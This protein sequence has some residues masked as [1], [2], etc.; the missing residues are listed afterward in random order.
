[1]NHRGSACGA[2]TARASIRA[3]APACAVILAASQ[4]P[5]ADPPIP[6]GNRLVP[7][8]V[9]DLDGD[10][11]APVIM[12]R[13]ASLAHIEDVN[14]R[15]LF[16]ATSGELAPTQGVVVVANHPLGTSQTLAVPGGGTPTAL[17]FYDVDHDGDED[18]TVAVFEKVYESINTGGVYG[19]LVE[20]I[21]NAGVNI[22][23]TKNT[24]V[25]DIDAGNNAD[26][27]VAVNNVIPPSTVISELRVF[28]GAG[29]GMYNPP[30]VYPLPGA[31]LGSID[32]GRLNNDATPDIAV[33]NG[34]GVIILRNDGGG[35]LSLVDKNTGAALPPGSP[36][37][38]ATVPF[39]VTPTEIV[40]AD[41]NN[42]SHADL[43]ACDFTN[44]RIRAGNGDG[45]FSSTLI[46]LAGDVGTQ[47]LAVGDVNG[48]KLPEIFAVNPNRDELN[49]WTATAPLVYAP[50]TIHA[51]GHDPRALIIVDLTGDGQRDL[52][53][54]HS[55]DGTNMA[56]VNKGD[57]T[58]SFGQRLGE[59]STIQDVAVSDFN[60]D[61]FPD[62]VGG[63][64]SGN[65]FIH[66]NAADG[67]G[68]LLPTE[69]P[70]GDRVVVN[71]VGIVALPGP[72]ALAGDGRARFAIAFGSSFGWLEYVPTA[73]LGRRAVARG[74]LDTGFTIRGIAPCDLNNDG[75]TDLGVVFA[76]TNPCARIYTQDASGG[77][78]IP[79]INIA[80]T[81]AGDFDRITISP[82]SSGLPANWVF[83]FDQQTGRTE[84]QEYNAGFFTFK[85]EF[86]SGAPGVGAAALG[87]IDG[88]GRDDLLVANANSADGT[89]RITVQTQI[90]SATPPPPSF[91]PLPRFPT[92]VAV[93]DIDGDGKA[94]AVVSTAG[95]TTQTQ[96]ALVI[97]NTGTS[98]DPNSIT[99]HSIGG[100]PRRIVLADLNNNPSRGT[101]ADAGPEI[102]S[103]DSDPPLGTIN[104]SITVLPNLANFAQPPA[105]PGDADGDNAVGL[106]D[107]ALMIQNWSDPGEPPVPPFTLGDL[108]GDGFVK[109]EDLA[110]VIIN[111]NTT[112]P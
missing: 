102:I 7:N 35:A 30:T 99:F 93:G 96:H 61:G 98:L 81:S 94:D 34:P 108:T 27:V 18:L 23:S 107:I 56:A 79:P 109:L 55:T 20:V 85:A 38:L 69:S 49:Q 51:V 43:V 68:R 80:T 110:I 58:F 95:P 112:C 44:I 74:S 57:G 45:T 32:L 77:F 16:T 106:S 41:V 86:Q 78:S 14:R 15:L 72:G 33:A 50:R 28:T 111:W 19:P 67:S 31:S 63:G 62:V 89:R 2:T 12:H 36:I 90:E 40:L 17:S 65:V 52:S 103:A 82:Q 21:A 22:A 29:G 1:M 75:R 6:P 83:L 13:P 91:L 39:P 25:A 64:G 42:D 11:V 97:L 9:A 101:N 10:G 8:L 92:N 88:D 59:S 48:D 37:V 84:V 53:I 105:C 100:Q 104:G 60:G 87:D 73:T 71:P 46:T 26:I 3:L 66:F 70:T 54:I 4:A 76:G 5:A 47:G 24:A